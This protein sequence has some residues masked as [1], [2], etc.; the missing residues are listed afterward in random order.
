MF[1]ARRARHAARPVEALDVR[2][3]GSR[4]ADVPDAFRPWHGMRH[5]AFTET[6]AAGVR[7]CSCRRRPG[8]RTARRRSV[9]CTPHKTCYPDAAE[10]AEA[11]SSRRRTDT[12]R[13]VDS[14]KSLRQ[15]AQ[16]AAGAVRP[17]RSKPA[18]QTGATWIGALVIWPRSSPPGF[19]AV[20][21]FAYCLPARRSF[22]WS[23]VSVLVPLTVDVHGAQRGTVTWDLRRASGPYGCARPWLGPS[24]ASIG[25]LKKQWLP[26]DDAGLELHEKVG[27]LRHQTYAH[28][29]RNGTRAPSVTYAIGD[30][31]ET[32]SL[33]VGEAWIPLPREVLPAIITLCERQ[34]RGSS[35]ALRRRPMRSALSSRRYQN[36]YQE[37][38][39]SGRPSTFRLFSW[40]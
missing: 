22:T 13:D 39:L 6:A 11:R 14:S 24:R 35:L 37:G 30:E 29:E 25:M 38:R 7:A 20:C 17:A 8:T 23:A 10:L 1:L 16:R 9:I 26:E 34:P 4:A 18:L 28:T 40:C 15:D 21:T 33:A 36:G 19:F 12:R 3:E 27:G 5:T 32:K 2:T 31:G